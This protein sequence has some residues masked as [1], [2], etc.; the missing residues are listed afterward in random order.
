MIQELDIRNLAII[1]HLK[2]NFFSG[3]T[4]LTGETGAGKSIIIDAL[5]LLT[6]GRGSRKLIRTGKKKLVLQGLFAFKQSNPV[7]LVLNHYGIKHSDGN[8][9]IQRQ[10]YSSGRNVCRVNGILVNTDV[11]KQL[12]R[13]MVDIQGQDAHQTL[14]DPATHLHLLDAF[15]QKQIQPLLTKY[16]RYYYQYQHLN[17]LVQEQ[18]DH[19]QEW[20]QRLDMLKF[21]VKDISNAHLKPHE[22][23]RLAKQQQRLQN[24]H[25]IKMALSKSYSILNGAGSY[26]PIDMI[27]TAMSEMQE[28]AQY[29]Q[30]F[31]KVATTLNDVYY[32]LQDLTSTLA[33]QIDNQDDSHEQLDQVE[34]R[35]SLI[36][37]LKL[38]YGSSIQ[39][40]FTYYHKIKRQLNRLSD[41]KSGGKK[42]I[43]QLGSVRNKLIYYGKRLNNV[44]HQVA[45]RLESDIH[46]QL[47]DLYMGSTRFQVRFFPTRHFYVNG[48]ERV[49]FYVQTNPGAGF[50]PLAQSASGGELSRIMLALKTIFARVQKFGTVVFDEIDT[51]VSGRVAQ[52]IAAKMI[53]ISNY[54]QVICISHLPQVAAMSDYH[55]QVK[56]VVAKHHTTTHLVRLNELGRIHEL[57]RM[58]AG[59]KVTKSALVHAKELRKLAQVAKK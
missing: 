43:D 47:A 48:I 46:R 36:D 2:I 28:I 55:Y 34:S 51:G 58:L 39:Q 13:L 20:A 27:G 14:M 9:I 8:V 19:H 3:M 7:Y 1:S 26:S 11:L 30:D 24:Y 54:S 33:D 6:G 44:R 32:D 57:A 56:K 40:I 21:Q 15:A 23:D 59:V 49:A 10:I 53:R 12:R 35:L 29:S 16:H 17:Q 38:K 25:N 42:L 52:A 18:R 31:K 22:D 5:N 41:D 37:R 4:V 45:K 50:S